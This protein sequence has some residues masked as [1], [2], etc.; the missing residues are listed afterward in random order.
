MSKH[1]VSVVRYE[2]PL[3]SVRR[4]V[5]LAGGLERIPA[6]AKVFIKP[7]VVFW[8]RGV[9]FPKWGVITTSR[10]VA[11]VVHLLHE[12]GVTDVTIGEGLVLGQA[13]HRETAAEAFDTLGYTRLKERYGVKVINTFERPFVKKDLGDGV[14]VNMNQDILESDFVVNLPVMKC[15]VQ[16]VVSLGVKNLKGMLDV[17]S[18]KAC[19]NTHPSKD[20]HFWVSRLADP[21]PP[22]LTVQ[23]GIFTAERGPGFD[24]QMHRS[25]LLA[26]SWDVFSGDKVGA[27]LLGYQ[28]GEV[29]H[30][31]HYAER[32]GRPLDLSDVDLAGEPLE[33]LCRPH[34]Y[35]FPYNEDGSL[36]TPLEKMGLQGLSFYKY[37]STT[38]TYCASVTRMVLTAIAR[39]WT[40]RP[41]QGVEVLTGKLCQ[42]RPGAKATIALGK[43]MY[44]A[45]KDNP[46]IANLIPV[47]GCPPQ[48]E[49]I[50]KAFHQA[51]IMVDPAVVLDEAY[52]PALYMK[53]YRN[54]PEFDEGLFQ[55]P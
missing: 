35:S 28:A 14:V 9:A 44:Q 27:R 5:D 47:K 15:H 4:A 24:G 8:C 2:Q 51:G 53:R 39:A 12:H 38:C 50:L 17:K 22:L 40:G 30:L 21:M 46:A 6:G 16:T 25:N 23:D 1:L 19:H 26:A 31:A 43:C 54:K 52:M 36:P 34:A 42:P 48:P 20:L 33:G 32:H 49:Q 45:H 29:P 55:V 10:V 18:R 13:D 7:N 3:E 41:W 37:D 11:D